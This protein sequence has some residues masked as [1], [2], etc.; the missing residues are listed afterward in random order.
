MEQCFGF[1]LAQVLVIFRWGSPL[2]QISQPV[3]IETDTTSLN[4]LAQAL[5]PVR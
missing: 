2:A 1:E 5:A 4:H 3:R